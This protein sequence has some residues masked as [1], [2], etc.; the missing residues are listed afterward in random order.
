VP[1]QIPPGLK[2]VVDDRSSVGD[3]EPG[4]VEPDALAT[5]TDDQHAT[6]WPL[7]QR[8]YDGSP[9]ISEVVARGRDPEWV[10]A[11]GDLDEQVVGVGYA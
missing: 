7:G 8:R 10:D 9:C 2:A 3:R 11:F 5:A 6:S 1:V 4:R